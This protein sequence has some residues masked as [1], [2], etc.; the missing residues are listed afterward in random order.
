MSAHMYFIY[1]CMYKYIFLSFLPC[2][3][4]TLHSCKFLNSNGAF[5][6][7]VCA[8]NISNA[9]LVSMAEKESKKNRET[10]FLCHSSN[11]QFNF[12]IFYFCLLFGLFFIIYL[13]SDDFIRSVRNKYFKKLSL[14][15]GIN[16]K[17]L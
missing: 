11:F 4:D 15:F 7:S 8:L 5:K 13:S 1:T 16:F 3:R 6:F 9:M 10:Y 12:G 2:Q 14:P 17:F